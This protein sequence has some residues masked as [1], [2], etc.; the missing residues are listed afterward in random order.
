MPPHFGKIEI[1]C[2]A[3][4]LYLPAIHNVDVVG[5][6]AAE[7]EVLLDEQNS[8]PLIVA[9]ELQALRAKIARAW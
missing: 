4:V 6:L 8:H 5:D 1:A 3:G 7:I 9:Q 2:R